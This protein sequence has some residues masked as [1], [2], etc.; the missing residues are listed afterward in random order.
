VLNVYDWRVYGAASPLAARFVTDAR[1]TADAVVRAAVAEAR[2]TAPGIGVRGEAVFGSAGPAL[3]AASADGAL[4]VV[5]SRGRGGFASLLLGSVSQQVAMHASGPVVVVRG[6]TDAD[7]PV[8][9]GVDGSDR[10]NNSLGFAFDEASM[11]GCGLL[12]VRVYPALQPPWEADVPTGPGSADQR[13][14]TE[15]AAV[16]AEVAAWSE[17][18]PDVATES[19]ALEGHPA[20]VLAGLTARASLAVVGHRGHGGFPGT[21]LGSVGLQLLH[22]SACP[23]LVARAPTVHL[24]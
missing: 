14:E 18:Y 6:R 11:R 17:K 5:G 4:V 8:V 10:S 3:V 12:A 22:H 20:E 23:V 7:G 13:R 2:A 9:V 15:T 1:E 24:I 19:V 21:L 16:L